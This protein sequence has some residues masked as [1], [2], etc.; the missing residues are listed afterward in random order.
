MKLIFDT[1]VDFVV[2]LCSDW[3]TVRNICNL[4]AAM[5]STENRLRLESIFEALVTECKDLASNVENM[6]KQF[7]WYVNRRI[8]VRSLYIEYPLSRSTL[9]KVISLLKH[10]KTH[11]RELDINENYSS[12]S[13][14]CVSV[15]RYCPSIKIL[16]V[17]NMALCAQFFSMLGSLPNLEDLLIFQCE[18]ISNEHINGVTCSSISSLSFTCN[19]SAQ[20]Q[21]ELLRMC[22]NLMHYH[23]TSDHAELHDLPVSLKSLTVE[24]C[25]N[26]QIISVNAN[27][28]KLKFC[29]EEIEDVHIVGLFASCSH[30]EE[31]D[32]SGDWD[33][34]DAVTEM[35]GDTY[36]KSL[37]KL[38]ISGCECM[39]SAAISSMLEKCVK[40][41]TLTL[42]GLYDEEL[43]PTCIIVALDNC[44]MLRNLK[45]TGRIITDE[46]LA[47]IAA[48]PLEHLELIRVG[49]ITDAAIKAL[50]NGCAKLKAITISDE[51]MN[52]L[53]KYMWNKLRPDLIFH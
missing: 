44:Q 2:Q 30:L 6:E 34:T 39:S 1:P 12:L 8:R 7:D 33:L 22:P 23:L 25:S 49:S 9:P 18:E 53:L 40:L 4:E 5:C 51:A 10:S 46:V 24:N 50:V 3:L 28:Q 31:L 14:I 43:D 45:Y 47:R 52:P 36:G 19:Y 21:A 16:E 37:T 32:I 26:V 13:S 17:A 11:M 41:N 27:L 35:I 20:V 48:A 15:A 29:C 42:G 38:D